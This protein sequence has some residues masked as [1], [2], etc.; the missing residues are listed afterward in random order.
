M[1][2]IFIL[3]WSIMVRRLSSLNS[4]F[5]ANQGWYVF[6]L[7]FHYE[8]VSLPRSLQVRKLSAHTGNSFAATS[9]KRKF[10]SEVSPAHAF[11]QSRLKRL[12]H[13]S[14]AN[15]PACFQQPALGSAALP[16]SSPL[17]RD[18][19]DCVL[20]AQGTGFS[21]EKI[22]LR[23]AQDTQSCGRAEEEEGEL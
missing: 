16:S 2:F 7:S 20:R 18:S 10:P 12:W 1:Q 14:P 21:L 19:H 5:E 15:T 8:T 3:L 6:N 22:I 11:E 17:P 9:P 4:C 13:A 23:E